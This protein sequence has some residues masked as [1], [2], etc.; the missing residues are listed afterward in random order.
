MT[1]ADLDRLEA[2]AKEA[3]AARVWIVTLRAWEDAATPAV[4]LALIADL[5]RKDAALLRA[6]IDMQDWGEYVGDY[7]I[8]KHKLSADLADIDAAIATEETE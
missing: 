7:Y 4:V 1:P 8:Q 3:A 2:L 6:R 5:R